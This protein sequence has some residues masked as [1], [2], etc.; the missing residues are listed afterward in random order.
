MKKILAIGAHADDIE[1]GCGAT[2]A[3]HVHQGDDVYLLHLNKGEGDRVKYK[4]AGEAAKIIGAISTELSDI[5]DQKFDTMSFL[6][7]VQFIERRIIKILPDIVYTHWQGDLNLDHK[8]TANAVLTACRPLPGSSVKEIYGF[9][10]P[11]ST[12]WGL[13]PFVPNHYV[14]L[15]DDFMSKKLL[16][17]SQYDGEIKESP[18]ARS[19]ET[20]FANL[21]KR[22]GEV[23]QEAAEAF[24]LY[25]GIK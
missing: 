20:I 16:A 22:G 23:G 12:E 18:H 1:L 13:H 25:R 10:I 15:N 21:I 14:S 3:K 6:D 19:F 5:P 17:L 4:A 7:I 11:S 9:E 8:I 2:L 24:Y